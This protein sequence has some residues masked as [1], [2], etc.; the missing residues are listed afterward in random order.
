MS[1]NPFATS[2]SSK[3]SALSVF[4]PNAAGRE[5]SSTFLL[6]QVMFLVAVAL[7]FFAAG[8]YIGRDLSY[9]TGLILEIARVRDADRADVR[10]A[11]AEKARRG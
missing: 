1:D 4:E 3:P 2:T 5:A 10:P 6:G 8:S 7:A 11:T 9:G